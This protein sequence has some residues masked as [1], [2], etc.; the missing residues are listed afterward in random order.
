MN[1]KN[2]EPKD[3]LEVG[4]EA[5]FYDQAGI[6]NHRERRGRPPI[7]RTRAIGGTNPDERLAVQIQKQQQELVNISLD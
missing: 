7:G 2:G 6:R 3:M 5:L 1:N 4:M